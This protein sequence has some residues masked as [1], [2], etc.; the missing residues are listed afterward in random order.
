MQTLFIRA[1]LADKEGQQAA[2]YFGISGEN[3][4]IVI[5]RTLLLSKGIELQFRV[6]VILNLKY[7]IGFIFLQVNKR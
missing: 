7:V 4:I 6:I 1:N 2:Q 3:P 5:C